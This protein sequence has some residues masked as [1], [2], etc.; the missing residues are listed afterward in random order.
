MGR[1]LTSKWVNRSQRFAVEAEYYISTLFL[2]ATRKARAYRKSEVHMGKPQ[3]RYTIEIR[4]FRHIYTTARS[5]TF[6]VILNSPISFKL[7]FMK[8][9]I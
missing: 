6:I 3:E 7:T 1:K 2:R 9:Q 8:I 5:A 4:R